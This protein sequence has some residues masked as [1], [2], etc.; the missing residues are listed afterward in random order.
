MAK[1]VSKQC[2]NEMHAFCAFTSVDCACGRCHHICGNCG[3]ECRVLHE[4]WCAP[5]RRELAKKTPFRGTPCDKCGALGAV[6][7]PR[8]RRNE[9]LC[10]R[11]H[12][13]SGESLQLRATDAGMMAGCAALP[14]D[15]HAHEFLKVRGLRFRCHRCK[16]DYFGPP[17]RVNVVG[18]VKSWR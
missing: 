11:C 7:N 4:G 8:H 13:E 16:Q 15:D 18:E 12:Q 17:S 2:L 6:R 1:T 14:L 3:E 5:C 10:I 9:Y